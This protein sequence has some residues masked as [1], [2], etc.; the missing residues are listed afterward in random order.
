MEILSIQAKGIFFYAR[1]CAYA[2]SSGIRIALIFS[3]FLIMA[4]C[5]AFS[6]SNRNFKIDAMKKIA[7]AKSPTAK[8]QLLSM[9]GGENDPF[10][11]A[12]V[13]DSISSIC[14]QDC[15]STFRASLNDSDPL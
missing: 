1:A 10:V 15:L 14:P 13:I 4:S 8:D 6:D 2:R 11:R 3:A 9:L 12:A 7:A 5:P